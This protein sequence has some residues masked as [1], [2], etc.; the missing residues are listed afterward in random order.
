MPRQDSDF[1]SISIPKDL[2][3]ELERLC[4][5]SMIGPWENPSQVAQ[6]AIRDFIERQAV[7]GDLLTWTPKPHQCHVPECHETVVL[8]P[9]TTPTSTTFIEWGHKPACPYFRANPT[10]AEEGR[11]VTRSIPFNWLLFFER[12]TR[13]VFD[14]RHNLNARKETK[15]VVRKAT[16]MMRRSRQATS[17]DDEVMPA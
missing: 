16:D 14:A 12:R 9:L 1:T 11:Q 15:E 10:K 3:K 2:H 6:L 8:L 17:G 13:E 7:Y 5:S 4:G